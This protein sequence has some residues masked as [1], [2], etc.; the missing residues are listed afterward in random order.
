MRRA[1]YHFT[2]TMSAAAAAAAAAPAWHASTPAERAATTAEYARCLAE[3]QA[4][5]M[6]RRTMAHH[7]VAEVHEMF[8][9]MFQQVEDAYKKDGAVDARRFAQCLRSLQGHHD[10]EDHQFFPMF[11]ARNPALRA[12]LDY[13][14]LDHQHLHPLERQALAGDGAALV[15]FNAFLL[16]H[17]RR[18]EML[19]VPEMLSGRAGM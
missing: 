9:R 3:W 11:V 10:G 4:H 14:S 2:P 17:L 7:L 13:L 6:W 19:L 5:K 12:P 1:A 18:E 16:D 8:R 15:E